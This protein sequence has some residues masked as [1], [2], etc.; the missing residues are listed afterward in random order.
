ME[1]SG[2]NECAERILYETRLAE[3]TFEEDMV[4]EIT[5]HLFVRR[6][7]RSRGFYLVVALLPLFFALLGWQYGAFL[8][9]F[10]LLVLSLLQVFY[11]T[12]LVW[13][14]LFI[15]YLS[16]TVV[17]GHKFA[18]D[19]FTLI[20]GSKSGVSLFAD[21]DDAVVFSSIMA[22]FIVI[23]IGLWKIKPKTKHNDG[24]QPMA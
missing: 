8:V 3:P 17:F 22:L 23:T 2:P 15:S 6:F 16:G 24:T 5:A 19:L 14:L 9:Y 21:A 13:I 20:S 10:P 1:S 4:K 7:H 18:I 11:P 12:M